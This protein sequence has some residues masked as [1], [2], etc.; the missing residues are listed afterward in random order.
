MN[1]QLLKAINPEHLIG[2][3]EFLDELRASGITN[4]YGAALYLKRKYKG[5]S[6]DEAQTVLGAWMKTFTHTLPAEDRAMNAL[7]TE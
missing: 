6:I 1:V 4:M 5:M 7:E 3:F 2:Y